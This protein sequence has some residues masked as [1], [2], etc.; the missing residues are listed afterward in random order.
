MRWEPDHVNG[1]SLYRAMS[2]LA[3]CAPQQLFHRCTTVRRLELEKETQNKPIKWI[4]CWVFSLIS[5]N[6]PFKSIPFAL[7]KF[8]KFTRF[9]R[10]QI[11]FW[12]SIKACRR[13][14][15]IG[16]CVDE[17]LDAA[18]SHVWTLISTSRIASSSLMT[19][20]IFRFHRMKQW[21]RCVAW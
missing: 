12:F 11:Q 8:K 9:F 5:F 1:A 20:E 13:I 19:V 6:M 7:K 16:K 3:S 15:E 14:F 17:Y 4:V 10:H 18:I 21:R 2:R